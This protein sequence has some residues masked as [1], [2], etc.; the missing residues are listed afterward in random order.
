MAYGFSLQN[1][2]ALAG[3]K[4][5]G[6]SAGFRGNG[7]CISRNGLRRVPW[8][9]HGL[10]EDLE[11]SWIVRLAGEGIDF[12]E[13]ATVFA[14]ML[15]SGGMPLVNQRRR[16]EFGRIAV[17]RKMFRPLLQ[18]PHLSWPRK[19]AAIVEL[20][21]HPTSHLALFYLL[22]SVALWFAI[23]EMIAQKQY[24]LMAFLCVSHSFA[25]LALAVHAFSPFIASLIPWRF[26]SSF[27]YF[28]Y[29]IFWRVRVLVKGG[30]R[31]WVR[32]PRES[33]ESAARRSASRNLVAIPP[34]K[35]DA[36]DDRMR[37]WR[38]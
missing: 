37:G 3:Q 32:T 36:A 1:G 35:G 11:Y 14:T 26:A 29:Y 31:S 4:A 8:N 21:S 7:M 34:F 16:W 22:L 6:L 5:L 23:P 13:D 2:I 30:P 12:V 10:V 18:T 25:T 27:F 20:T 38:A 28:P 19:A 17:R 9:A 33:N 24:F 15:S